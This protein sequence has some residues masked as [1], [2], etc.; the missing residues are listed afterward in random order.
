MSFISVAAGQP[1]RS[2][3]VQQFTNWLTGSKKDTP[4]TITT[5]HATDYTLTLTS[6]SATGNILK[7]GYGTGTAVAATFGATQA[8]FSSGVTLATNTLRSASGSTL[9][10]QSFTSGTLAIDQPY[11]SS[12]EVHGFRVGKYFRSTGAVVGGAP[13]QFTLL[14]SGGNTSGGDPVAAKFQLD[15]SGI[16][17]DSARAIEVI[18]QRFVADS[19]TLPGAQFGAVSAA[20]MDI[21]YNHAA[22]FALSIDAAITAAYT[23]AVDAA[24]VQLAVRAGAVSGRSWSSRPGAVGIYIGGDSTSTTVGGNVDYAVLWDQDPYGT[25]AG[26]PATRLWHVKRSGGLDMLLLNSTH[27]V[28]TGFQLTNQSATTAGVSAKHS[29][30]VGGTGASFAG[31]LAF[32]NTN[33]A[34]Y[35]GAYLVGNST[36]PD[37]FVVPSGTSTVPGLIFGCEAGSPTTG[38]GLSLSTAGALIVS[39]SATSTASFNTTGVSIVGGIEATSGLE[40]RNRLLNGDMRICQRTTMPTTDDSYCLDGWVLLLESTNAAVVAQ[41]TSDVP[42]DGSNY[43]LQL[44]VGSTNN[45]KFGVAQI[46]E[47]ANSTDLRGRT[48]SLQFKAK[49]T[50]GI[51]DVRAAVI[52]WGTTA[53]V[54]TSDVVSSWGGATTNPTLA[55]NWTYCNTAANLSP[56][57][58]WATYRVEGISVGATANNL[59]LLIWCDD[60]TTTTTTDI[61]RITDVQLE[62]GQRCSTFERRHIAAEQ[63]LARWYFNRLQATGQY[64]PFGNGN[65]SSTTATLDAVVNFPEMRTAPSVSYATAAAFTVLI[66]GGAPTASSIATVSGT[67]VMPDRLSVRA[68]IAS[69]PTIGASGTLAASSTSAYIEL[70]AEL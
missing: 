15:S 34:R 7:L 64:A 5:T 42:T 65:L 27:T 36:R 16:Y 24:V 68:T 47:A 35:L 52:Q 29:I 3:H 2:T 39:A 66:N 17:R 55:T 9:S 51:S 11:W 13:A 49:A 32:Y 25:L 61:L 63:R 21:G 41:S 53:D 26:P 1:I 28:G 40:R 54:V 10:I 31:G 6:E 20:A 58:S 8:T 59:G 43:A 37:Q 56:T 44:T 33:F 45:L 30:F 48:V 14:Y 22:D 38:V 12:E 23:Y 50:A 19:N 60:K 70:S 4:G 69:Q 18:T 62:Q 57:T 67:A 46:L